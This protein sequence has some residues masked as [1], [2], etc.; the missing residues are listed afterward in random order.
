MRRKTLFACAL[1][2]CAFALSGTAAPASA[3]GNSAGLSNLRLM[4]WPEY[5]DPRVLVQFE[6][7][8]ADT[9]SVPRDVPFFIPVTAKLYATAYADDNGQLVNTE[10]AKIEQAGSGFLRVTIRVSKPRFHVEYYDDLLPVTAD[11]VM[12]FVYRAALPVDK[13]SLEIQQP[14]K[15]ENFTTS[16]AADSQTAGYHDFKYHVF[17]FA[18]VQTDQTLSVHV[19][20]TKSDPSPSISNLPQ[21]TAPATADAA[22]PSNLPVL[23]VGGT[24]LLALSALALFAWYVR[25]RPQFAR[26]EAPSNKAGRKG[27]H[28]GSQ[29]C[30]QCGHNL[31]AADHF[32]AN[33]GAKRRG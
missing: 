4:V 29:F 28:T 27:A 19:T 32:C 24:G 25:R 20:Y 22:Q 30:P 13:V 11:K 18:N 14:I 33:C 5:D 2:L 21:T 31:A 26:A 9:N 12:D 10:P 1:L 8:L 23:I 7:D 16:P 15:A 17:S 6:G 3:A